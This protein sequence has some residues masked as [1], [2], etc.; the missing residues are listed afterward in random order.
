ML[1]TNDIIT[2]LNEHMGEAM[3]NELITSIDNSFKKLQLNDTNSSTTLN[4]L[5]TTFVYPKIRQ[6]GLKTEVK[7]RKIVYQLDTMSVFK[8]NSE[9]GK[10]LQEELKKTITSFDD[11]EYEE[12]YGLVINL[13]TEKGLLIQKDHY[14]LWVKGR[15]YH[16]GPDKWR[17]YGYN[18]TDKEITN[19]W[20]T[21]ERYSKIYFTLFKHEELEKYCDD[22]KQKKFQN[23]DDSCKFIE[24]LINY[25][26]L[27]DFAS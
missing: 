20:T 13:G 22:W 10:Q 8:F 21:S 2:R 5:Y 14:G 9:L 19:E 1:T 24:E 4:D 16:W 23:P 3:Y 26:G 11:K 7:V 25:M 18:E 6:Y 17:M 27:E 15:I 12:K